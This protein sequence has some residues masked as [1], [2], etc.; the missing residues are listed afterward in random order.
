MGK[1]LAIRE[2]GDPVLAK[3]AE[4]ID[5]KKIDQEVLDIIEDL[6]A[7]LEFSAGFGIAAPQVGISKKIIVIEIEKEKCGYAD[8]EDVPNTVMIN[9]TWKPLS[10]KTSVEFEACLSVPT[11]RGK[12]KRYQE[13]EVTYYTQTGEKVTKQ[14]HGFTARDIQHECDH[15]EGMVFLDKVESPG[16][17]AT[18]NTI[19]KFDLKDKKAGKDEV[20][21]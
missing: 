15:L 2:V 4:E 16:G 11:I 20:R 7:T 1:I 19:R 18:I 3:K 9:P 8:C 17:F 14:V 12:V 13:I 21:K 10:D 5:T 6:K